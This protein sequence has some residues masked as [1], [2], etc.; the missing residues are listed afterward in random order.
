LQKYGKSKTE[1]WRKGHLGQ[2]KFAQGFM[3]IM[4]HRI[5]KALSINLP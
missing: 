4:R 3:D 1:L 2:G 5:K